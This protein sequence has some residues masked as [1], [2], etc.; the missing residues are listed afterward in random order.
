MKLKKAVH[1]TND[2][3]KEKPYIHV[4]FHLVL[5]IAICQISHFMNRK[6]NLNNLMDV[7]R[8]VSGRTCF[9]MDISGFTQSLKIPIC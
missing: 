5:H 4:S 9:M 7:K 3:Y 8:K 2:I 1:C 6:K